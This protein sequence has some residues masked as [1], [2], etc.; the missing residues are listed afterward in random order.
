MERAMTAGR[1]AFIG[2]GEVGQSLS[3]ALARTA[4][5]AISAFD[6]KF[7]DPHSAPSKA[8]A[9]SSANRCASA[10]ECVEGA[11]LVL[12]AVT[13]AATIDAATSAAPAIARNVWYFDLNSASPAAKAEAA[14]LINDAGGRYIEASVMSPINPKR[15]AAPILLGGPFATEFEAVARRSGFSGAAAYADAYGKTAAAK[16]CRSVIIK[17]MEALMIEALLAARHYGVVDDVLESLEDL[18]PHPDWRGHARYMISRAALHG[19]RRA[20][21]MKE[22]A[23]SV[24]AAGVDPLMSRAIAR[25]QTLAAM[26]AVGAGEIALP[27]LLDAMRNGSGEERPA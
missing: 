5:P 18:I 1:I 12:S 25:R 7:S 23:D 21:E 9:Q 10:A 3:A 8:I 16:L 17:G 27:A 11:S 20:E 14:R 13:A 19:A 15:L 6:I 22:A 24:A 26:N 2:F 4:G